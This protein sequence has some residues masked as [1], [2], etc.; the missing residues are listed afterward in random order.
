MKTNATPT[1]KP[2]ASAHPIMDAVDRGV[3]CAIFGI[4]CGVG[5][6]GIGISVVVIGIVSSPIMMPLAIRSLI[7]YGDL[8]AMDINPNPSSSEA[9]Y[10]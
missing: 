7:K 4:A 8:R 10:Y 9:E 5:W 2:T 1:S 6:T 3:S